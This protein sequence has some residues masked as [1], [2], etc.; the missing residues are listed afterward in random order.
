MRRGGTTIRSSP[1]PP[2][3]AATAIMVTTILALM[4][5]ASYFRTTKRP[6]VLPSV[7]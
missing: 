5:M 1:Q 6:V 3:Q 4:A 7:V 2:T